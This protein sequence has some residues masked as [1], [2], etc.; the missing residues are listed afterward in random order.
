MAYPRAQS[1]RRADAYP[2]AK[3]PRRPDRAGRTSTRSEARSARSAKRGASA[4]PSGQER[5]AR[6]LRWTRADAL[7]FAS[8]HRLPL[9]V[10]LA[11]IVSVAALYGPTCDL[12]RAWRIETTRE[13][14]LSQINDSNASYQSDIDRLQTREGIEDEARKRGY[15]EDGET[16]VVVE[17]LEDTSAQDDAITADDTPWYLRVGDVIF[18]YEAE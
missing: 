10:A 5:A 2:A 16:S 18:R 8:R 3:D 15:V 11:V 14:Q 9:A 7:D 13:A 6:K 1:R 12:Y 4:T 17:G